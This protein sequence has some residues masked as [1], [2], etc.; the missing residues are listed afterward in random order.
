VQ[1]S[2]KFG[3]EKKSIIDDFR[4]ALASRPVII[5]LSISA[6]LRLL[7]ILVILPSSPSEFGIDEG[8]YA[9]LAKYVSQGLPVEYF[10]FYGAG[11]YN[12]MKS[13]SLPSALLIKIGIE[14]LMAVRIIS[15]L[16]G[17]TSVLFLALA[18]IAYLRLLNKTT[19][20]LV[21]CMDRKFIIL[22]AIFAFFPSNFIWSNIG[23]RESGSQF[24]LIVT[25]YLI[26]KLLHSVGREQWKFATLST[27]ALAIAYGTRPETALVFSFLAL[28]FSI[29]M[30]LI[31][32]RNFFPII[33]IVL[34]T[35][36][37]QVL[38]S[39]TTTSTTT[40]T[41]P[42]T[43]TVAR[44]V[45]EGLDSVKEKFLIIMNLENQRNANSVD[46][47]SALPVTLCQNQQDD[48]A[49]VIKC[50]LS[51][52]PFRLFAFLFRPM[53]FFDE[54]SKNLELA[55]LENLGWMILIPFSIWVSLR[56][57]QDVVD[58]TLNFYLISFV[59][60]FSSAAALHEG[61]LGTGFRHKST[62][63]WPLVFILMIAPRL[64]PKSKREQTFFS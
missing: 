7:F 12:S 24:W 50:N 32:L 55:A 56:K 59:L 3:I 58:R 62:I 53:I 31:N 8:T 5:I 9:I 26:L 45:E 16:Y 64:F 36:A 13:I 22:L 21:S 29:G 17:L 30:L 61:N 11:L 60:L 47:K 14:E 44:N 41:T 27:L 25:F 28:L 18:F 63:L 15:S 20:E 52:L 1:F 39:S 37:G 6:A 4:L 23:L 48:I 19:E 54:G 2:S 35:L 10:P 57:R 40:S 51:E 49:I 38:T 43:T 34:G 42:L 46:A 33:V